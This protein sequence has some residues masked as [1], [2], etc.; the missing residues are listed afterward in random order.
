MVPGYWLSE[1][2]QSATGALIDHVIFSHA[3]SAELADKA[4]EQGKTIYE[5]L[6]AKLEELAQAAGCPMAELTRSLH[7]LPYFHGNRSPRADASLRG[8]VSGLK[9]SATVVD[10]ALLYLAAIQA[11]AYGTRHIIEELNRNGY[12][13]ETICACGGGTKNPVYLQQ[14][15]D[16]T[17]CRLVLSQEPEAVLLGSAILGAVASAQ[18][19]SIEAA[20]AAMSRAGRVIEPQAGMASYHNRKYR[21]FHRL[22]LDHLAYRE[23]MN[24]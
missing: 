7:M 18:F 15:A 10:L 12:A 1:G 6:N 5:L 9:L 13:I 2:G 19:D 21:V 14:H 16:I 3:A 4:K 17:G 22:Y 11:V 8:V 23:L 24:G 20:M